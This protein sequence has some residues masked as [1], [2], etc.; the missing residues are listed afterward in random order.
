MKELD[1]FGLVKKPRDK[2]IPPAP[3]GLFLTAEQLRDLAGSVAP[4]TNFTFATTSVVVPVG[5]TRSIVFSP[6]NALFQ[7]NH[8][9]LSHDSPI[10]DVFV[11]SLE[12]DGVVQ[13][14]YGKGKRM[15]YAP[16]EVCRIRT[17]LILRNDGSD[18]REVSA[19]LI[20]SQKQ[21]P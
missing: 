10:D 8:Y 17:I 2:V 4:W 14:A 15:H 20:G 13:L 5:S 19:Q 1:D 7:L 9:E 21:H 18:N 6:V 16:F 11:E 12:I 3:S